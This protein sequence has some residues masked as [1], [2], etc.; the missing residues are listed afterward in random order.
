MW[1]LTRAREATRP[2][3]EW[4]NYLYGQLIKYVLV[5]DFGIWAWSDVVNDWRLVDLRLLELLL[6]FDCLSEMEA[7]VILGLHDGNA[8]QIMNK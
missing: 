7:L 5:N 2:F 8:N 4:R 6:H 3:F 1:Y